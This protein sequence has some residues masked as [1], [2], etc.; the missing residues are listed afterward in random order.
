MQPVREIAQLGEA[1]SQV[2][3][4]GRDLVARV[5]AEV[6]VRAEPDLES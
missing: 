1:R 4:D 5:S 3:E 6:A 2:R